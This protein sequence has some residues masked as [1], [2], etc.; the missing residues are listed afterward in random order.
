MYS[1]VASEPK[2]EFHFHRG[3]AYAVSFLG[4]DP[5]EL[6]ALPETATASFAG[7]GN[8]LRIDSLHQGNFARKAGRRL[9]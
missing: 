6:A 3:A 4:Y 5:A 9:A 7:V 1:R 2:G 8:P